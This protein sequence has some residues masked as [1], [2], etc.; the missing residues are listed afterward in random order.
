[1]IK[2]EVSMEFIE[3]LHGNLAADN[4]ALHRD[5]LKNIIPEILFAFCLFGLLTLGIYLLQK[6]YTNQQELL[7]SKN[8]LISNLTHELK[9]PITTIGV[10]LEAADVAGDLIHVLL[11]PHTLQGA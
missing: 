4:A 11:M 1:M 10:A 7:E 3:G 2:R 5:A 6:S 8:N 9:T